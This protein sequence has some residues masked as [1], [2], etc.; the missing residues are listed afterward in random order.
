MSVRTWQDMPDWLNMAVRACRALG[1]RTDEEIVE[2]L[3]ARV[4]AEDPEFTRLL[5]ARFVASLVRAPKPRRRGKSDI[6]RDMVLAQCARLS[7]EGRSL[8]AIG[9]E[10]GISRQTVAN[11]IAE[12]QMCRPE[13]TPAAVRES[14]AAVNAERQNKP[15]GLTPEVDT[16]PNVIPLRRPA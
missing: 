5:A 14:R 12:W 15:A 11:Y 10:L 7:A 13:M 1:N 8:R 6:A 4:L 9:E 3:A 2:H 16:D